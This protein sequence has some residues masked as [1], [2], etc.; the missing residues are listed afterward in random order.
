MTLHSKCTQVLTSQN[1]SQTRSALG[2]IPLCGRLTLSATS[3]ALEHLE[4]NAQQTPQTQMASPR[5]AGHS[6]RDK[7]WVFGGLGSRGLIHHSILGRALAQAILTGDLDC[8]PAPARIPL[9]QA[10]SMNQGCD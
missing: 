5:T 9:S 8:I 1:L 6:L 2:A 10:A 3:S 7:L 4:H